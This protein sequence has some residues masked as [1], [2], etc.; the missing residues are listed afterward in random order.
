MKTRNRN[1]IGVLFTALSITIVSLLATAPSAFAAY[2]GNLAGRPIDGSAST[3]CQGL[4]YGKVDNSIVLFTAAHCAGAAGSAVKGPTGTTIGYWWADVGGA[5]SH[6]FAAIILI[7]GNWPSALNRIYRGGSDWIIT[8]R[9]PSSS[10]SCVG[11]S[12]DFGSLIYQNFQ[13]TST[14]TTPYRTGVMTGFASNGGGSCEVQT[15]IPYHPTSKDSGSSF[16]LSGVTNQVFAV[17]TRQIGG[18]LVATP[19]YEGI[20]A[21]DNYWLNHGAHVGAWFCYQASC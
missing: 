8:Q 17:A 1:P 14:S 5:A 16:L 4:A 21:L 9:W 10:Y 13:A 19:A 15:T 20:K 11:I 12:N 6:D 7:S 2:T 3:S 18:N